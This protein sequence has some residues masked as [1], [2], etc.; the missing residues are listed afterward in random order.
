MSKQRR[1]L[2]ALAM[3]IV[4][5]GISLYVSQSWQTPSVYEARRA[6]LA[7]KRQHKIDHPKRYDKP[8]ES[9]DFYRLQRLPDGV[10]EFPIEKY[11]QAQRH[12]LGMPHYSIA[13]NRPV[14]SSPLRA[15]TDPGVIDEWLNKGPG[16]IG[17]RTRSLLIHPASP[18]IM[19]AAGVSS[20]IWKSIDSG[21]SWFP[22]DDMMTNLAVTTMLM[23][24]DDPNTIYAGTGEG[25]FNGDA[26]RGD[27]VF[28]SSDAGMTWTQL[29]ATA[30]NVQFHYVNKLAQS[31]NHNTTLYAATRAG[32]LR[33]QD[34]G[35]TWS[36]VYNGAHFDVGCTDLAVIDTAGTDTVLAAC[37]S[38]LG[39]EIRR[40]LDGG[41]IWTQVLSE[42][43]M[44]R[45]TLAV[46]PS[47]ANIVY[48][49]SATDA[50]HGQGLHAVFR[51]DD[52]GATWDATVRNTSS[53]KISTLLL[54]NPIFGIFSDC[55]RGEDQFFNQGWY[56]NI[57][58]VD[59]VNP[60]IVWAG[61]ID[62]FRSDDGGQTFRAASIWFL[63]TNL[64]QYSHADQ[65]TIV[66]HPSYDGATNTTLFVGND[67]GL[68]R[69]DNARGARLTLEEMCGN[70][71]ITEPRVEWISL[72]NGYGVTQFYHG[73]I[74]PDNTRYFGGTQ[75][76]GTIR[77]NDTDGENAWIVILGGDGGWT[78]LDPNNTNILFAE[79]FHLSIQKSVDGGTS[80]ADATKGITE[81]PENFLFIT[82][83]EMAPSDANTL[84]TGATQLWRTT[85]QAENW[86]AASAT[87][88]PDHFVSAIA[89]APNTTDIVAAGTTSGLILVNQNANDA[90]GTI[91]WRSRQPVEAYV[92][93][94]AIDP[95]D[96][97][98]MYATYSTFGV[99][100]VWKSTDGG[101]TWEAMVEGLP[102][103]PV[104]TVVIDPANSQHV[105][106]G[107]DLGVFVSTDGGA[108]WSADGSGL[109]NT[110]VAKLT[111]KQRTL[112]AF[113]HG[114]GAYQVPLMGGT[115]L[116]PPT[117]S[118]FAFD[119][120]ASPCEIPGFGTGNVLNTRFNYRDPD[121]DA[122]PGTIHVLFEFNSGDSDMASVPITT[123]NGFSGTINLPLCI[124]FSSATTVTIRITLTDNAGLTSNP[125]GDTVG[126][127]SSVASV[128]P[129]GQGAGLIITPQPRR[130]RTDEA[131]PS[132]W[133][134]HRN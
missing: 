109:A 29:P 22:L 32:V 110:R 50:D 96:T 37:G 101:D 126:S 99:D 113:T 91:T 102:D 41:T 70:G 122:I 124:V 107:T 26:L 106:I 27:G 10:S 129:L 46:A 77:G 128:G 54:S 125:V 82:P 43:G 31:L 86:S 117:L 47:N 2:I 66:F 12:I 127:P 93:A 132:T 56:D 118:D 90:D 97:Q 61:G 133:M 63:E 38:F 81:D 59:P 33:S 84:W 53:D 62:L 78:A 67:G 104:T 57:I 114:R 65:H 58:A 68:F 92:S 119:P 123:G 71:P 7:K 52:G 100:K 88:P 55:D 25:F 8:Q 1:W 89:I 120:E 95:N 98:T 49:L 18:D 73:T 94:L 130:H 13:Q 112:W 76:N 21:Q 42:I 103:I 44:G 24:Q 17:G 60:D 35:G 87:M 14:A 85:D 51:S 105:F 6:Y 15:Q 80:F 121:G 134:L 16:N 115:S 3:I 83:F 30:N 64:P 34:S 74:Y 19:Y 39:G 4:L 28:M 11:A 20:G 36:L 79:N 131:S 48:A 5:A 69:T 75:D 72:N 45:S 9:I 116:S 108:S 40:S 23:D 111:I